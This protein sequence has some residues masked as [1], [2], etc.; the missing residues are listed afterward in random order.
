MPISFTFQAPKCMIRAKDPRFHRISVAY[1][2]F[3]VPEGIPIPKGT[4]F[5]QPLFVG[6][7]SV[8]A[9]SSQPVLLEE[10]EEKEKEEE[11]HPEGALALS[12]SSDRFEVFNQPLSPEN[13]SDNLDYQQQVDIITSDKI[14]IQRKSQRSL[15]DL[16]ESQP[17]RGAPGKSTQPKLP[18]PPPKSPQPSLPSR[19]DLADLKR[20]REQKG[21]D[22]VETGRSRPDHEDEIQR[23]AKQQKTG[24]T[25]LK[26]VERGDNQPLESQAWLPTLMLNGEPLKEDASLRNFNG[27]IGCHV[28][29]ILE[30][31]LLL[32]TDIVELWSIRKNEVF[33]NL[34][35]YFGMV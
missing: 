22:V 28:A 1:E 35:R 9:S 19:P 33:L 25:S 27:G 32:P 18:H 6:I 21:K 4:S 26:G 30:E 13:T 16:I 15:L 24:Q 34:K 12:D 20:K 2:G 29:S 10:E 23:A 11:E 3:I 31:A 7:P 14:G 8:G 17:G 5:T